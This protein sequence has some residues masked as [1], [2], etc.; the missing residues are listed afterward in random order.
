MLNDLNVD[1]VVGSVFI[2]DTTECQLLVA[3]QQFRIRD[4]TELD[5]SLFCI[6]KPIIESS[7]TVRLAC[8]QYSYPQ[9]A[10]ASST[11]MILCR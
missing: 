5:I 2:R 11:S 1:Y 9:L 4:C 8:Y 10:G 7:T 6:T 3:C